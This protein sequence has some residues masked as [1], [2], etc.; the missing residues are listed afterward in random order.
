[1]NIK[2]IIKEAGG[3]TAVAGYCGIHKQAPSQWNKVPAERVLDIY[4]G[5]GGVVTPHQMRP[6]IYPDPH[7]LPELPETQP[8]A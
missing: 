2:T 1:M 6:D 3:S 4:Y 5:C 7:W 8:A